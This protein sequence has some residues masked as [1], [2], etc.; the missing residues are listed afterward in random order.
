MPAYKLLKHLRA[1]LKQVEDTDKKSTNWFV[2]F[3]MGLK[4]KSIKHRIDEIESE[5]KSKK[6]RNGIENN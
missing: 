3:A 1:S 2:H 4:I 6:N 5:L